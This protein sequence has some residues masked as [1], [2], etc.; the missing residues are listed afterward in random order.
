MN[1]KGWVKLVVWIPNDMKDK[2]DK[3]SDGSMIYISRSSIV[4]KALNDFLY[5]VVVKE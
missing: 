3:Y 4:R 1:R 2:L 5:G